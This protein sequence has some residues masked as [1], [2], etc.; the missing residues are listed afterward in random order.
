MLGSKDTGHRLILAAI[1]VA[2]LCLA[3]IRLD[4]GSLYYDEAATFFLAH[5]PGAMEN[6]VNHGPFYFSLMA[7]WI[8]LGGESEFWMR[9]FSA[10][11]FALT[12]PVVYVIGRT[13]DSRRVGL[14]A[15]CLAATSPLLIHH[16]R[17]ARMYPMLTLFCSLA[18][19]SAALIISGWRDAQASQRLSPRKGILWIIYIAAVLGGMCS[20]NTAAL[21]PV[22][23][24]LILLAAIAAAPRFRWRKLRN[25]IAANMIVLALYL[26][27]LFSFSS[28]LNSFNYWLQKERIQSL[29]EI[30]HSALPIYGNRHLFIQTAALAGL[31]VLALWVW[32][33]RKEW[34]WFGFI[35]IGPLGFPMLTLAASLFIQ[36]VFFTRVLVWAS[37]PYYVGCA[38]GIV[39]LPNVGLRRIALVG[40][41]LGSL[42]GVDS[43]HNDLG[44]PW[45]LYDQI[46]RAVAEAA[47]DDAVVLCPPRLNL[48]FNYYWRSHQHEAA[49]FGMMYSDKTVRPFQTP[50]SGEVSKWGLLGEPRDVSSLFDD[51]P[52]LWLA[53][54]GIG[55]PCE[56]TF[57]EQLSDRGQLVLERSL[58]NTMLLVY[59]R[60]DGQGE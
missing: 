19:M 2:A 47:P 12:A 15:A 30:L 39:W 32:R 34:D 28:T 45:K 10:L 24:T 26:F 27:Y 46:A 3:V 53:G 33:R 16:A 35:F 60:T 1:T 17:Q 13:V 29:R 59:E 38:A 40:L 23:T 7:F 44:P 51:Y 50:A 41:L 5:S 9:F 4:Y 56:S 8:G 49:M 25:L 6:D 18:L 22:V 52:K 55:S 11:C 14:Y 42:Y 36:P 57:Q 54:R 43:E 21:L 37:I 31:F 20:H 58:G 48:P